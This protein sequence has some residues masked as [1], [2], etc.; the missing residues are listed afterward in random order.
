M[1][2]R[3]INKTL[4]T[5]TIFLIMVNF[6]M[7]CKDEM[8]ASDSRSSSPKIS[9]EISFKN[10]L[11]EYKKDSNIKVLDVREVNEYN[12]GHV[13]KAKLA[14]LSALSESAEKAQSI[15]PYSKDDKIYVICRSGKRSLTAVGIMK[16]LG[17]SNSVSVQG[18]TMA[19]INSGNNVEK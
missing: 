1:I 5:F 12:S 7:N 6:S 13:P 16:N 10:F 8:S 19:W 9:N 18:G 15:I 14:P 3:K 11:D 17:Y 2:Q 4:F